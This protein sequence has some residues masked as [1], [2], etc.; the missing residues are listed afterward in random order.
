MTILDLEI[1][2]QVV[3]VFVCF[4]WVFWSGVW[5]QGS[6]VASG[7]AMIIK[8]SHYLLLLIIFHGFSFQRNIENMTI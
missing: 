3:V 1:R 5:G 2:V 6:E 7:F 8:D 4:V